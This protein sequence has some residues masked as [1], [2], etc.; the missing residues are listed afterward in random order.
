[1]SVIL[2]RCQAIVNKCHILFSRY[3]VIL[4][5]CQV[6]FSMGQA[7][8]SRSHGIINRTSLLSRYREYRSAVYNHGTVNIDWQLSVRVP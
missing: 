3:K 8:L 4:R 1:M 5:W 2:R 7:I 6:I